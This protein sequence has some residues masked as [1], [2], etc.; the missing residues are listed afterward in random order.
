[1]TCPILSFQKYIIQQGE[2]DIMN[3]S[4]LDETDGYTPPDPCPFEDTDPYKIP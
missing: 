2:N 3:E 4:I 1:M